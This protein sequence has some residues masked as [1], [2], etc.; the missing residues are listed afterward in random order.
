MIG[1]NQKIS[2]LNEV[3]PLIWFL[4]DLYNV[5]NMLITIEQHML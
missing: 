4:M 3:Q 1:E 5:Y 2:Q